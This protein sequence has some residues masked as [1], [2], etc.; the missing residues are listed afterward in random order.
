MESECVGVC[1]R[2]VC[3]PGWAGGEAG[4]SATDP[5]PIWVTAASLPPGKGFSPTRTCTP[6]IGIWAPYT[7]VKHSTL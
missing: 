6:D 7:R 4:E 1:V 5:L 2:V 3:G